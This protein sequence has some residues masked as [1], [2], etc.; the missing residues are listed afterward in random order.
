MPLLMDGQDYAEGAL[1]DIDDVREVETLRAA[2]VVEVVDADDAAA[3]TA[4][5]ARGDALLA[6]VRAMVDDASLKLKNGYPKLS[7]LEALS[8]LDDVTAAERDAIWEGYL[9]TRAQTD[10]QE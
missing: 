2:G 3:L 8:G 1:I 5:G 9:S 6:A 10:A 4:L 7:A